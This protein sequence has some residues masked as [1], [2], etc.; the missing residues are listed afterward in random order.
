MTRHHANRS[1]SRSNHHQELFFSPSH[2]RDG[3]AGVGFLRWVAN[4]QTGSFSGPLDCSN[5]SE[6]ELRG[7]VTPGPPVTVH[8]VA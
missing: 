1:K 3:T 8:H 4:S 6:V 5:A 2:P 7:A